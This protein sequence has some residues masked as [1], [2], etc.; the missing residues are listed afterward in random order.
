MNTTTSFLLAAIAGLIAFSTAAMGYAQGGR[1]CQYDLECSVAEA[2][3][4]AGVCVRRGSI[5]TPRSGEQSADECGAD[6]RCRLDR[7]KRKNRAKRHAK[8][9]GE[10]RRVRRLIEDQEQERLEQRPRENKPLSASIRISR[11]G[12]IGLHAG[13]IFLGRIQPTFEF[14]YSPDLFVWAPATADSFGISGDLEAWWFRGGLSY[15]LLDS[16]FSPYLTAGFQVGTG[17][18]DTDNYDFDVDFSGGF[19]TE[20]RSRFHA[21]EFGGGFDMQF[22]FGLQTRLGV[23]YRPLIYNQARTG[24]GQYDPQTRQGLAE[25]YQRGAAVDVVWLLGWAI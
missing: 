3:S 6:R 9:M 14:T 25:W 16:W 5:D 12:P 21:G 7:L 24:P 19:G 17:S 10:E 11:L 2:C 8:T 22:K 15:F 23:V 18:Y 1:T 13:Y 4:D 20:L